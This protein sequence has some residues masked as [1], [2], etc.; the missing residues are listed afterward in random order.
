MMTAKPT[1]RFNGD[2]EKNATTPVPAENGTGTKKQT[3]WLGHSDTY[4]LWQRKAETRQR[5][6]PTGMAA[7]R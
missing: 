7:T 4:L 3:E 1:S 6:E 5:H 2:I